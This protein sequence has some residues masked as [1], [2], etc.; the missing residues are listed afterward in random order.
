[1]LSQRVK[2]LKPSPTLA[3]A[4]KAKELEEQGHDVISLSVG[5]PDWDTFENVKAEGI[6]AIQSGNTKYQPAAGMSALRKAIAKQIS[7]DLGIEYTMDEVTVT[8]GAKFVVFAALQAVVDPGDQVIVGAPYWVSYP[9]MVELADG[10]PLAVTCGPKVN[11]KLTAPLL[12]EHIT[13]KVKAVILNSPS[14]PTGEIYTRQELKALGEVLRKHPKIVII[15]DDIYNRLVFDGKLAPHL[16]QECPD[17]RNRTVIVNGASKTYSMTGWRVG[18]AVGPKEVIGAMTKYQSQSVSCATSISQQA[19]ITAITET[20]DQLALAVKTLKERV[21]YA[22]AELNKIPGVKCAMPGGAFY[23]WP[24]VSSFI[25]KKFNGQKIENSKMLC[26][27]L[28][29]DQKVAAVPGQEF[30]LDGFMRLSYALDMPRMKE[31]IR[32]MAE[33][34]GKIS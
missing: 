19:C 21:T 2:A 32:R 14:N 15:S 18:W 24:D 31:A 20:D 22:H 3:L 6:K 25:G 26:Q 34:F 30:G 33:F 28:L 7:G 17:L 5:E 1:M 10:I 4:A 16:L 8:T 9:T 23:L 29:E 13:A 27:L 12:E 11:Y